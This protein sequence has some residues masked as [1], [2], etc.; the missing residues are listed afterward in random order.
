[1]TRWMITLV[2]LPLLATPVAAWDAATHRMVTYLALDALAADAPAWLRAPDVQDRIAFQGNQ[3]DRWRGWRVNTLRHENEPDHYFDLDLLDQF[4][5]T[6]ETLPPLRREYLRAMAVSKHVHPERVDAY[7]ASDDAARTKEWPGFLPYAIAEHYAKLQ[8]AFNEM[9][10]L[11]RLNEPARRHQLEQVRHNAVYHMGLLAHFVA[12]AAQPLHT[13]KHHHGWVGDNPNGY[14]SDRGIHS[15]IDG[16]MRRH[17]ELTFELLQPH[18]ASD[19][20][21]SAADPWKDVLAHIQRAFTQ[22]EPLYRLERDS[23]L[24]NETGKRFVIERLTDAATMLRALYAAAYAGSV[25]TERQISDYVRYNAFR[26]EELPPR[27][28]VPQP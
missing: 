7:D 19:R 6:V 12:D 13:T 11:E 25:P 27:R 22:L 9:Q 17:H 10:I 14:T 18:I 26:P 24:L 8:A 1:M 28:V 15:H 23:E 20:K 21:V 3:P 2:A 16:G 5:L 4:G